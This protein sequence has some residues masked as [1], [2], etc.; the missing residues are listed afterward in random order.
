MHCWRGGTRRFGRRLFE[1][2]ATADE[3]GQR[4]VTR[5]TI[6]WVAEPVEPTVMILPRCGAALLRPY[7]M[8]ASDLRVGGD[9]G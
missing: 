9:Y 6:F 2:R 3:F 8:V 7:T 1:G 5:M 4:C